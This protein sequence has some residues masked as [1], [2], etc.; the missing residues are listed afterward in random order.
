M[1][2][3]CERDVSVRSVCERDVSVSVCVGV[4]LRWG[5]H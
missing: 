2:S 1:R 5:L 4:P 3:V